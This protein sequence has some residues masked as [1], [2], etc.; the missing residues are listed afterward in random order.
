[1]WR[2][3]SGSMKLHFFLLEFGSKPP[4]MKPHLFGA[5]PPIICGSRLPGRCYQRGTLSARREASTNKQ[6]WNA[7]KATKNAGPGGETL[8]KSVEVSITSAERAQAAG[9]AA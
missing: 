4:M 1:M 8:P 9:M 3:A 2:E 7:A 5:K 6:K